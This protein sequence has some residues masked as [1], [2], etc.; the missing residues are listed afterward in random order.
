MCGFGG[1]FGNFAVELGPKS[2][3]VSRR[4]FR[5]CRWQRV[6]WSREI[7]R[8]LMR[9]PAGQG[10]KVPSLSCHIPSPQGLEGSNKTQ[11]AERHQ[12][13]LSRWR[14]IS[15]LHSFLQ[16]LNATAGDESH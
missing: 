3:A 5:R 2:L 9:S 7:P 10:Q 12:S 8:S 6:T 14:A 15:S 1:I 11:L 4:A 13:Q 16:E